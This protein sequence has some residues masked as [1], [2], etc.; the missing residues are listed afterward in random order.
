MARLLRDIL[1]EPARQMEKDKHMPLLSYKREIFS[2]ERIIH[3][4]HLEFA[5][6][7]NLKTLQTQRRK[8]CI[9]FCDEF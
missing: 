6:F 1:F 9:D 3:H 8:T 7:R 4:E 5:L 2:F